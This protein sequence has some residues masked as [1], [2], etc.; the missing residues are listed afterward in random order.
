MACL[1]TIHTFFAVDAAQENFSDLPE[2]L[3]GADSEPK[4]SDAKR[5][6]RYL[7]QCGNQNDE[8]G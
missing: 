1:A 8:H 7:T 2:Q 5:D 4:R 3:F 6:A